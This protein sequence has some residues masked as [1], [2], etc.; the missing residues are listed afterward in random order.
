MTEAGEKWV[1]ENNAYRDKYHPGWGSENAYETPERWLRAFCDEVNKRTPD[2]DC[3]D[4]RC[5]AGSH[6]CHR[7]SQAFDDLKDELLGRA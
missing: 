4:E 7:L 2:F 5:V 1:D 3:P 6:C